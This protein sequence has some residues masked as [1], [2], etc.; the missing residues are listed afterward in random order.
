[1]QDFDLGALDE[2]QFEQAAL[3]LG[4]AQAVRAA[5]DRDGVDVATEATVR[6]SPRARLVVPFADGVL[7]AIALSNTCS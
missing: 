6:A 5:V 4:G 2:S 3:E 7:P 1:M